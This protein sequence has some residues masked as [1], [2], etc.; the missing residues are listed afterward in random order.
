MSQQSE[1]KSGI[2]LP[3]I[4]LLVVLS[5]AAFAIFRFAD[6][7]AQK[8]LES[9]QSRM[10]LVADSRTA[11]VS[12]WLNRHLNHVEEL[13]GDASVQLY[14]TTIVQNDEQTAEAQRGYIFSLLSAEAEAGGFHEQRAIDTVAANVR[15]PKRAGLALVS[16]NGRVLVATAGMPML[17][18]MELVNGEDRSFVKLGPSLEDKTPLM[19]IGAPIARSS[20]GQSVSAWLVGARPL[21]QDFLQ[22]L[23]QPGDNSST[24]ETYL[25]VAGDGDV[26]T[27][28]TPLQHGGRLGEARSDAAAAFAARQ[29]G[30]FA[31]SFNYDRREVLVTGRELSAPVPWVLVRTIEMTEAFA[32]ISERRNNLLLTLGLAA[33]SI[34]VAL[35][36]VWRH[37]VSQRLEKSYA[38]QAAL[39]EQNRSL[40]EFLQV[41][42]DSQPTAI[43]ALSDDMTARLVN[44]QMTSVANLPTGELQ[45]RRIDTL[46]DKETAQELR[47]AVQA[48]T[49]GSSTTIAALSPSA[50]SD[51]V[52][53]TDVLPLA[54][55]HETKAQALLVMQD[56]TDLVA[57]NER[58]EA[59]FR[60]LIGTLTQIIDARDPWS[61]HHSARVADVAAAIALEMEWDGDTQESMRIA[62]QL[63]NL[64]KIF[65]PIDILTKQSPLTDE[66]LTLV[67]DS[68]SKGAALI[69]NVEL[70]GS[71]AET[72]AQMRENWDGSGEPEGLSG[73][74]IAPGAR[75]L[76]VANAFV[77]IVSARAHR[78]SLGFDKAIDI[79]QSDAGTRYERRAVAAL[80][81]LLENKGG[82]DRWSDFTKRPELEE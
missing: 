40:S 60:Q 31:Q 74:A 10:A 8:G 7:E 80:Q 56:I 36:L 53:K 50:D 16:G 42:S 26:V 23:D 41:V 73:E 47:D 61:K 29:P 37:G 66:E 4:G 24:A 82:R 20:D 30:G 55:S 25:V 51:R 49:G 64:G 21:D 69:K 65:V 44:K 38:E 1:S 33:I 5:L 46:F 78:E 81:N 2:L 58:S 11:E 67:R 28:I 70:G 27:A 43:A 77:G 22:T 52:F 54:A 72:L 76:S 62:G 13:S 15:R 39:S 17:R 12:E 68:M 75:V 9:W 14:A 6:S 57:A 59:L 35:I 3:A 34:I 18:P 63:V 19:L 45:N 32:D 79:L 71:V 48:A